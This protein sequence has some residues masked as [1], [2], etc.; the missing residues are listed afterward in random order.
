[1][2]RTVNN[3]SLLKTI[4][5]MVLC[6]AVWIPIPANAGE[7][8][9][10]AA[11]DLTFAFK[12]VASRFEKQTGTSVKLSYGSSGNFFSQIQNG[13]PYDLFFSADI[14]Y[15]KKLEA[16]GLAEPGT[17]YAYATAPLSLLVP[18]QSNLALSP[19]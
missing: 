12:D 14:D 8:T 11:S 3:V 4:A 2:K 15:P 7:I 13:A 1:M 10:A 6:L 9:I 17:I 16:A 19:S 5:V 18:I